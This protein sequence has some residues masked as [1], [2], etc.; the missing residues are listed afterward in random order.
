MMLSALASAI[1]IVLIGTDVYRGHTAIGN[2][3]IYRHR[4]PPIFWAA[5]MWYMAGVVLILAGGIYGLASN[6]KPDT[7]CDPETD[8]NC[9]TFIIE[10]AT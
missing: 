7:A 3:H 10:P 5:I 4:T 1:L 2:R 8:D 9:V 6:N